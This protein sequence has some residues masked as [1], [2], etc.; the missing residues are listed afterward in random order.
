[1]KLKLAVVL[2]ILLA[3]GGWAQSNETEQLKQKVEEQGKQIEALQQQLARIER[4]L[5]G[6]AAVAEGPAQ[7]RVTSAVFVEPALA[8]AS[9]VAPQAATPPQVAGFRFG[10][11]F[12][13]R[14][15]ASVRS[16]SETITGLQNMRQRYRLRFNVDRDAGTDLSMHF[17]LTT[18]AVNNGITLDQ[19]FAGG[20]TRHPMSPNFCCS[21]ARWKA[22]GS[23]CRQHAFPLG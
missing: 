14:Y 11:D 13:F 1:M 16:A 5:A 12:R 8:R 10:A 21:F 15:D 20:I 17:Q 2:T 4:A 3:N 22:G 6:T 23:L 18:G 9:V 7:P 19:D